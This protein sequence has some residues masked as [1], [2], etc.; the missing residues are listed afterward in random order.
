MATPTPRPTRT[1]SDYL[2]SYKKI[3][4]V[5]TIIRDLFKWGGLS[6]LGYCG[7]LSVAVLA[8]R[9]T[10]ANIFIK[11]LGNATINHGLMVVLAGGGWVYGLGQQYLRRRNIQRIVP[12]KNAAERKLDPK[13]TSSYLTEQGTTQPGNDQ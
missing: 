11:I 6:F 2:L 3:D 12:A 9:A 8:G 13:R 10:T 7:Y 5:T 4:S 1:E